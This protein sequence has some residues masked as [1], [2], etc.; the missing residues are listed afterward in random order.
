[1]FTNIRLYE[2]QS[3]KHQCSH[4]CANDQL[5]HGTRF[6]L[7]RFIQCANFLN[8][9]RTT[10][11][12]GFCAWLDL[13]KMKMTQRVPI[14]AVFSWCTK[15]GADI[16]F[17]RFIFLPKATK[18][19][20]QIW[21][22]KYVSLQ[23]RFPRLYIYQR[24]L[25]GELRYPPKSKY[26]GSGFGYRGGLICEWKMIFK[27][28]VTIH[29]ITM[30][31]VFSRISISYLK[32]FGIRSAKETTLTERCLFHQKAIMYRWWNAEPCPV[33]IALWPFCAPII[34][35]KHNQK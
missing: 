12:N 22:G 33:L 24:I 35:I 31:P 32:I 26:F 34:G 29:E 7:F 19:V 23:N 9:T 13:N 5:C 14:Y 6:R 28:I 25:I 4:Q 3:T 10:T 1:M 27:L 20:L 8:L 18:K 16:W 11:R 15:F 30:H 2:Q 21:I 17:S